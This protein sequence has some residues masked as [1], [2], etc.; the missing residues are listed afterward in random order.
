MQ[1]SILP[2]CYASVQVVP[3]PADAQVP[4]LSVY[5]LILEDVG[6]VD[7]EVFDRSTA[8]DRA[9][10]GHTLMAAIACFPAFGVL[11]CDVRS[12]NILMCSPPVPTRV[13]ILD[14]GHATLRKPYMSNEKWHQIVQDEDE[15]NA[16]RFILK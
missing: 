9:M 3:S 8:P 10:L 6:G 14:F 13:V 1:G 16:I 7:L 11:H 5:G 2:H 12:G 4:E 15:L